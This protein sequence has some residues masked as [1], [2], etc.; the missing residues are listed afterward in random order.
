M[1]KTT[2]ASLTFFLISAILY[3]ANV[4]SVSIADQYSAGQD[5]VGYSL[6]ILSIITLLM[7]II[8]LIITDKNIKNS[9]ES[10]ERKKSWLDSDLDN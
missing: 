10:E 7:G 4:I 5:E 6:L 9:T 1:M 2:F 3:S 8:L